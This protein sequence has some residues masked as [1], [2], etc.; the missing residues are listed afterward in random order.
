[1]ESPLQSLYAFKVLLLKDMR[2][3]PAAREP[4]PSRWRSSGL[5]CQPWLRRVAA[6]KQLLQVI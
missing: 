6:P 2:R 5:C 3:G 1:M 4:W